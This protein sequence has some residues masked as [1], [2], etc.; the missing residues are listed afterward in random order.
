MD[1]LAL[2]FGRRKVSSVIILQMYGARRHL[3]CL[4]VVKNCTLEERSVS[5]LYSVNRLGLCGLPY[6]RR[7]RRSP[8]FRQILAQASGISSVEEI[9]KF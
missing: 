2:K 9:I 5:A 6:S 7:Q 3:K 1:A 8:F 4:R